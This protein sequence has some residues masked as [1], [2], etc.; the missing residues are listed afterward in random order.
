GPTI[1]DPPAP[2]QPGVT[3]SGWTQAEWAGAER[4]IDTPLLCTVWGEGQGDYGAELQLILDVDEAPQPVG[5]EA[6]FNG[7]GACTTA[8]ATFAAHPGLI[9]YEHALKFALRLTSDGSGDEGDWW[10]GGVRNVRYDNGLY[11]VDLEGLWTLLNDARVQLDSDG[12]IARPEHGTIEGTLVLGIGDPTAV[13]IES[14]ADEQQTWGEHLNNT[15]RATPEAAWGIGPDQVFVMGTP[16]QGG[17]TELDV[18]AGE[19]V[20]DVQGGEFILPPFVTDVTSEG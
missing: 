6:T 13:I 17:I 4:L 18:E 10:A 2:G 1:D 16:E 3:R 20:D 7:L 11:V 14:D 15:F 12:D 8:Q 9:P 19:A 5:L